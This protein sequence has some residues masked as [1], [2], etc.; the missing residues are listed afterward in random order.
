MP[1]KNYRFEKRQR[2]L[3][4]QQHRE[5]KKLRQIQREEKGEPDSPTEAEAGAEPESQG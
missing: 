5:E 1:K 3:T 4:K 2:E